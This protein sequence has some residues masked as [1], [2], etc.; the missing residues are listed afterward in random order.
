MNLRKLPIFAAVATLLS[1][2][3]GCNS[4]VDPYSDTI[5]NGSVEVKS[6]SLK[7]NDSILINLDSVFF[8]IDLATYQIFNADSLPKGTDVSHLQLKIS[9]P[10]VS[11]CELHV[12]RSVGGDT[13]Y[14]YLTSQNDSIDFS[15]GPVTLRITSKDGTLTA[16]YEIHVNV[17]KMEPDSLYWNQSMCR[18]LPST[19]KNVGFQKTVHFQHYAVCLT[20]T[21]D[22]SQ[23]CIAYTDNPLEDWEFVS[24]PSLP[25]NYDP[26]T[27]TAAENWLCMLDI[28]G[29]L[30]T[31][32]DLGKTWTATDANFDYIL[33]GYNGN[34]IGF[35]AD[36]NGNYLL[37]WPLGFTL[38]V[39]S[40]FPVSGVSTMLEYTSPWSTDPLA[41][42]VGGRKA[43]GS[44]SSDTWAYD[45]DQLAKINNPKASL[46][47]GE[48][49]AL[50]PYFAF[51]TSTAW[52][53]SEETIIL[54]F[55]GKTADGTID[56]SV[57]FTYDRGIHWGKAPSLMQLPD[58]IPTFTDAQV[59]CFNT[60]MSDEV[61]TEW[62][63]MPAVALPAWYQIETPSRAS[64]PI[65]HWD[66]PSIYI[67]GGYDEDGHLLN[68][69]WH[70]VINRLT[71]KPLY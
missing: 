63:L 16:D 61:S 70:G 52:K 32:A 14:N 64:E 31:S 69:V 38:A 10:T 18:D 25:A 1:A 27:L 56:R 30:Y 15:N 71:F 66:C 39:P 12:N 60:V 23:Y 5:E 50:V 58:Y 59:L 42:F 53:V 19:L 21:A 6:F 55:G 67:F 29:N 3:F 13:I 7:A 45:G 9:T 37:N 47:A 33:G 20:T 62:S 35:C 49:Y 43:D 4:S 11:R 34:I 26:S 22:L 8:S 54:A 46:P 28:E 51:Y 57:Y 24:S 65:T 40:D 41:I 48:D 44:L 2:A 17:H 36:I 68:S